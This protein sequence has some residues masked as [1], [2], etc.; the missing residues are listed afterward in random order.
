MSAP[1]APPR[2]IDLLA[3]AIEFTRQSLDRTKPLS[4]RARIFWAAVVAGRDLG[5]SDVVWGEFVV[6]AIDTGLLA[7]LGQVQPY[8]AR[9]TVEHLVRWGMLSR[10]PFYR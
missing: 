6:L 5:A 9:A 1:F 10:N 3:N 2:A 8:A 4:E 7:H